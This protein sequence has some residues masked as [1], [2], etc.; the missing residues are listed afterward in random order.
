MPA[1]TAELNLLPKEVWEKGFLGQLLTWILSVGRYV[2]VFTELIV[3][4]AFLYR[5]GLDRTLTDLRGSIKN[6]QAII[7]GFG[8]L[9][10]SFR[11]VQTKLNTV[12]TVSSQ[13][14][15]AN[16]LSL[17]SQMVP[18]DAVLTN[19]TVNQEQVVLEGR[20]ASQVGLATL[21]NQA[22]LKSEFSDVVLEN[23]KSATD[24]T[25]GIEFRL[26]MTFKPT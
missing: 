8:D 23:V 4:S 1:R 3:I 10:K 2:V 18:V 11:L 24:K 5:F 6:K 16:T 9:E 26:I 22:Q 19:I 20:V 15:V 21:L 25:A 17:L 12:K 13:P 14:R 7:T